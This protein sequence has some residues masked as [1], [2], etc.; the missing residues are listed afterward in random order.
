MRRLNIAAN[1]QASRFRKHPENLAKRG[2]NSGKHR[3]N[4]TGL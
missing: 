2:G 3:V 4:W 1:R